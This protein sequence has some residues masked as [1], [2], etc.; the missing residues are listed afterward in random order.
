MDKLEKGVFYEKDNFTYKEKM[1]FEKEFL[2]DISNMINDYDLRTSHLEESI[3]PY[4]EGLAYQILSKIDGGDGPNSKKGYFL[5]PDPECHFENPDYVL[6]DNL[7]GY[8]I[9]GTLSMHLDGY[10]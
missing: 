7:N 6:P 9:A 5:I 8:D 1:Q 3:R 2:E 10:L 4:L